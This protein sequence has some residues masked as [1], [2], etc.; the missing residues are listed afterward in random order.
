MMA[1]NTRP[2]DRAALTC[3]LIVSEPRIARLLSDISSVV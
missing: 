2:I 3:G 1:D